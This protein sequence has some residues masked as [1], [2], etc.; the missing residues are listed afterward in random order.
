MGSEKNPGTGPHEPYNTMDETGNDNQLYV[1]K[2]LYFMLQ[3][4]GVWSY[5]MLFQHVM[6]KT[7]QVGE[8]QQ[9]ST[10]MESG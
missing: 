3:G 7:S 10:E 1:N 6:R 2:Q 4:R 8:A 5:A 9:G